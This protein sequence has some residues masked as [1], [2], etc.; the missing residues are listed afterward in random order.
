MPI[1]NYLSEGM[2]AEEFLFGKLH[3]PSSFW[4]QT[5]AY[6]WTPTAFL[7]SVSDLNLIVFQVSDLVC[8]EGLDSKS[9]SQEK[10]DVLS[11]LDVLSKRYFHMSKGHIREKKNL[12]QILQIFLHSDKKINQKDNPEIIL[13]TSSM[14]LG[15]STS[16]QLPRELYDAGCTFCIGE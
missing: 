1:I 8:W 15:T 6:I 5:I 13:K 12:V 10:P 9:D 16:C 14:K 11:K 4:H 7:V 2:R 3:A